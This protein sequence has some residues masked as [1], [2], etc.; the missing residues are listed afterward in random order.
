MQSFE[1]IG[2]A[3]YAQKRRGRELPRIPVE[4]NLDLTYR[5]NNNCRHCWIRISSR[6]PEKKD[7]LSFEEIKRIAGEARKMGCQKWKISGGEPMLRPDF[8]EIF[9]FLTQKAL[10]YSLN[11]N[12]T[13]ITP[14]IARLLTRKGNKMVALYG[15]TAAVHDKVTRTPGSFETAMQGFAYLKEA[16]AAFTVQLVPMRDNYH[17]F[18]NM[19]ALARSLSPRYRIGASWLCL[20]A[21]GSK[22]RNAEIARQRLDPKD[23][24]QFDQPD[25]SLEDWLAGQAEQ[26]CRINAW[27]DHLYAGCIARRREFFIDPYGGMT[28]C[29][30]IKDPAFRYDLRTGSFRE[31]WETF[32]TSLAGWV[33]G[34]AEYRENCGRCD[35]RNDCWWCGGVGYLE[36]GR[37]GAKVEYLC[38]VARENR[39]FKEDWQRRHCRYYGIAGITVMVEADLPITDQTF[40]AK[41]RQFEVDGPGPDLISIRHHF[42]LPDISGRDLGQEVHRRLTWTIYRK[43]NSWI[44]LFA[45]GLDDPAPQRVAVFN[46]D[47]TRARIYSIND[48]VFLRGNSPTL[49]LFPTDQVFLAQVLADRDACLF[50]SSGV[51]LNGRGLLFVGHSEAGKSTLVKMLQGKAEILCDD[52]NIVRRWPEGLRVHGSWAHGEVP[53]VS[54]ASAPLAAICFLQKS[55]QNR[56]SPLKPGKEAAGNLISCLMKSLVSAAWWQKTLAL[57]AAIVREVPFYVM[58]FDKSGKI[59]GQLEDLARARGAKEKALER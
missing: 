41:F 48:E 17:Q 38:Q 42:S 33:Q 21:C 14:E 51:I 31:A 49:T 52:H 36:H 1:K 32:L 7:E 23:V 11:T 57:V 2:Q 55:R 26:G 5:C 22:R 30:L 46:H 10:S 47:Y 29:E 59:A 37:H 24:I 27:D 54:A 25:P 19:V 6:A 53:L 9:D 40:D 39:A 18:E 45:R 12:G 13:L 28:G 34:G 15:A 8:P 58:E 3:S 20:S 56:L 50:H 4:G 43:G 44:Y 35:L 16:G